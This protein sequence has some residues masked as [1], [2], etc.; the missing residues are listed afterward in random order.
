MKNLSLLFNAVLLVAVFVL[1]VFH[2]TKPANAPG[3]A[4]SAT[5]AK[6]DSSQ[7]SKTAYV[8]IDSLQL[9]YALYNDMRTQ[10]EG[11]QATLKNELETKAASLQKRMMDLEDKKAKVLIT[12]KDFEAK[13]QQLT[14][15]QQKLMELKD[16][17]SQ[18]FMV[19]Q[20][21]MNKRLYDSVYSYLKDLSKQYN[22]QYIFGHAMGGHI[23]Y[24]DQGLNI[25][26]MVVDGLNQRYKGKK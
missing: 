23:L 8:Y 18:K 21:D 5:H 22:Y 17:Y 15:E 19:E 11:K 6:G 3:S 20:N 1:Y 7:N 13:A 10:L 26:K 12:Q 4:P 25:T 16:N 24:A 14:E 2:F 9:N